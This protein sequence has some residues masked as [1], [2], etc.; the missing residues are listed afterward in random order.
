[1]VFPHLNQTR[2]MCLFFSPG[3]VP[4]GPTPACL[5]RDTRTPKALA[6]FSRAQRHREPAVGPSQ[7]GPSQPLTFPKGRAIWAQRPARGEVIHHTILLCGRNM[8]IYG[9]SRPPCSSDFLPLYPVPNQQ[10]CL[11]KGPAELPMDL[12][13]RTVQ[14]L[15]K[16]RPVGLGNTL[17]S[18]LVTRFLS[19][20][21]TINT[22]YGH[23]S[24]SKGH[25]GLFCKVGMGTK[26]APLFDGPP[27]LP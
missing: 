10:A 18:G 7:R 4:S 15:S 25:E 6:G 27:P 26:R 21:L 22:W 14:A 9:N 19:L 1:M 5:A 3:L 2:T 23:A 8:V 13:V 20:L 24:F 17:R 16:W 11:P 12:F